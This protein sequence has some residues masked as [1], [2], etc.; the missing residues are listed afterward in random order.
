[1]A[2]HLIL[3]GCVLLIGGAGAGCHRTESSLPQC[4][5]VTPS[6]A[7]LPRATI[8]S[9]DESNSSVDAASEPMVHLAFT[10]PEGAQVSLH[11]TQLGPPVTPEKSS[12][13][14]TI[15]MPVNRYAEQSGFYRL[16]VARLPGNERGDVYP[17]LEIRQRSFPKAKDLPEHI[18]S[19]QFTE[20]DY[21]RVF[22]GDFFTHVVYLADP[23]YRKPAI[24]RVAKIVTIDSST[25]AAGIDPV[26]EADRN[27][28][29]LAIIHMGPNCI[30]TNPTSATIQVD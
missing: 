11:A 4:E 3:I 29:I 5:T 26:L 6:P 19:M 17:S 8:P 25:L 22:A 9:K 20:E 13:A 23:D 2:R 16:K 10:V 7:P 21:E 1:M 12:T 30:W 15:V 28:T 18:V 24:E 27:G 14:T